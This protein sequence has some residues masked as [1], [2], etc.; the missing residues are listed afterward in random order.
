M[1]DLT[2]K[3][4]NKI[5]QIKSSEFIEQY[6]GMKLFNYQKQIID[7]YP[8][9][10]HYVHSR[11]NNKR[12]IQFYQMCNQLYQ[13]KDNDIVIVWTGKEKRLMNRDEF[14][15]YLMGEYWL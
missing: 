9:V 11:H 1:K 7:N 6:Y 12:Q 2:K 4:L 5:A 13:M 8:K 3:D 10:Y 15:N 14:A